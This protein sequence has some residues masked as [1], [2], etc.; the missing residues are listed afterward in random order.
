M[1][2][3]KNGIVVSVSDQIIEQLVLERL[4]DDQSATRVHNMVFMTMGAS[5]PPV[6]TEVKELGGVFAGVVRGIDRGDYLLIVGPEA[7]GKLEWKPA[8]DWAAGVT[9]LG[10]S[11]FA[12]FNRREQ[13]ICYANVPDLFQPEWYW[14]SEQ[15][16]GDEHYAWMQDFSGGIQN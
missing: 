16:A 9:H 5:L 14:S 10:F 6:A 15:Y 1:D 2:F 11:D 12:L 7:P 4:R 13:A 3:K 8:N